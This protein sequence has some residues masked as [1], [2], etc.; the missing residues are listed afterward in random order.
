MINQG[1]NCRM[2]EKNNNNNLIEPLLNSGN[3][4][5][6]KC[7]KCKSISVQISENSE[8]DYTCFECGG[9]CNTLK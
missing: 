6:L 5:K 9:K 7:D 2:K 8:P 3:V 4:Y 1:E